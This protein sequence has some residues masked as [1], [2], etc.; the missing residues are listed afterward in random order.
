MCVSG[1]GRVCGRSRRSAGQHEGAALWLAEMWD[2]TSSALSQNSLLLLFIPEHG[3]HGCGSLRLQEEA[4]LGS[5]SEDRRQNHRPFSSGRQEQKHRCTSAHSW[6]ITR[7]LIL[8]R[9]VFKCVV[10]LYRR[11]GSWG[12]KA[13]FCSGLHSESLQEVQLSG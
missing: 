1:L 10:C 8:R 4:E 7:D 5:R 9:P 6:G 11:H 3:R 12:E 2:V 13:Q